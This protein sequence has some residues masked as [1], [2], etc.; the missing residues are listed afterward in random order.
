MQANR[1]TF[2]ST[3]L[4][5]LLS[6]AAASKALAAPAGEPLDSFAKP[7][8]ELPVKTSG[9]NT[10]RAICD[11]L[12]VTGTRV[13]IH[14]TTLGIGAEPHPPHRHKH[15]EFLLLIKGQVEVSDD[16]K[17]TTL[18]PGSCAYWRS[19]SLH[20]VHNTGREPA[21]YFIVGIGTD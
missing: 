15:D 17:S 13:E 8:D 19:M 20:H 3:S 10:A 6:L 2:C 16:G 9:A 18:G 1:R 4:A 12:A 11:G 7:F 5:S 14:E 21:Q